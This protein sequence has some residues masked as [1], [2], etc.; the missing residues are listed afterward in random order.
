MLNLSDLPQPVVRYGVGLW[1]RR[2]LVVALAWLAAL[3]GW[4]VIWLIPDKY[5]SRAQVFVQTENIL[6]PVMSDVTARP[7]YERRVEVMQRALLTRPNV[8]E[9]IYRSGV[10][11]LIE[12]ST[13][14][15]REMK[16][17]EMVDW[18]AGEIRITSPQAMYF[19]IRYSFGDPEVARDVV[20]AVLELFIEQDLGASL[21]EN[22]DAKRKLEAQIKRFEERLAAKDQE[23]ARFRRE[24]AAEL[25]VA[26]GNQRNREQLE[27]NISRLGDSIAIAKRNVAT[28]QTVLA[29]TPRTSSGDELDDL[30]VELAQ[31]RSQYNDNHPD[32]AGLTARIAELEKVG[33]AALPDNPAYTRLRNELRAARNEAAALEQREEKLIGELEALSFTL[34]AAPAVEADLQRIIRDYEQTQKSYEELVE[35]RDRLDLTTFL[36][37]GAQGVDYKVLERPRRAFK[38]VS[39]PRLLLILASIVFA[40]GVGAA[41]ALALTL[42]DKT[43]TQTGELQEAFGLPVLGAISEAPSQF[44]RRARVADLLKL[45]AACAALLILAGGYV[46]WEVFRPPSGDAARAAHSLPAAETR[47]QEMAAWSGI[48]SS[49]WD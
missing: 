4:F 17:A 36:G 47:A 7:D 40:F 28:L 5:E 48:G 41:G 49:K 45:G 8:E 13:P 24:H 44:V 10:D 25:A 16:M 20:A 34:A 12:A 22:E 35:S 32:I 33:D 19:D 26:S 3:F 38:P 46:Y 18:V 9:I 6:E 37:P 2:W 15:Q 14:L 1:R 11:K 27:D 31:L 43:Y 23:V 30:K 39:P 21:Q 29:S 42:I